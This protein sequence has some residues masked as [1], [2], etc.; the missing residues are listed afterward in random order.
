MAP[1]LPDSECRR[2]LIDLGVIADPGET[3]SAGSDTGLGGY[4]IIF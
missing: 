4:G 1:L 3:P 2:L